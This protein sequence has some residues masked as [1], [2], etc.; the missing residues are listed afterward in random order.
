RSGSTACITAVLSMV[1]FIAALLSRSAFSRAL[2]SARGR[3]ASARSSRSIPVSSGMGRLHARSQRLQRAQ[4]QLLDGALAL[5]Q[6]RCNVADAA[7]LDV[8]L[9]DHGPLIGGA[10]LHGPG[11]R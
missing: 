5:V 8:T 4:L 2:T 11:E 3:P 1:V 9:D 7:L 6:T 10:L